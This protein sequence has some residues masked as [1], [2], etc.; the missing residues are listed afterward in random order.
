VNLKTLEHHLET[1]RRTNIEKLRTEA[2]YWA[3]VC[4]ENSARPDGYPSSHIGAEPSSAPSAVKDPGEAD[5]N[6]VEAAATAR[7]ALDQIDM[8][9]A[10]ALGNIATAAKAL[11]L[12]MAKFTE[13]RNL[14]AQVLTEP[15]PECWVLRQRAD[16]YEEA[17]NKTDLGGLLDEARHVSRWVQDYCRANGF[18]E[19]P[20]REQCR[21]HARGDR[22]MMKAS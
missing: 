13:A 11:E 16:V 4:Q 14:Q 21:A 5:L 18:K 2:L 22:V 20:T 17:R 15:R 9:T 10:V 3:R 12:A 1:I 8:K 6:A 19:L 7:R